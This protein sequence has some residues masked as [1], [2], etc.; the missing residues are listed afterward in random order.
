[1]FIEESKM[2]FPML[3]FWICDWYQLTATRDKVV[4]R[5]ITHFTSNSPNQRSIE[6]SWGLAQDVIDRL[7]QHVSSVIENQRIQQ[8]AMDQMY[9]T[10]HFK[11]FSPA[12]EKGNQVVAQGTENI[13][14]Q[15][16]FYLHC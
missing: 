13:F 5:L 4:K 2:G 6:L 15:L 8:L 3:M 14:A 12:E 9:D 1:M 16:D 7:K 10:F 11:V